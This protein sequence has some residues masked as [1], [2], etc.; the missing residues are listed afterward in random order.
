MEV[1]LK[2]TQMSNSEGSAAQLC[3][4]E[5]VEHLRFCSVN[6]QRGA[7]REISG[8]VLWSSKPTF[9]LFQPWAFYGHFTPQ[10]QLEYRYFTA[11]GL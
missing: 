8:W 3:M 11:Q 1:S 6:T 5:A 9:T 7:S 2:D 4:E 10:P